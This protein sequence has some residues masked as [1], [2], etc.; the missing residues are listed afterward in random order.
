M[1]SEATTRGI[2]VRVRSRY[3]PDHSQPPERWLFVYTIEIANEG[4]DTVQLISRHWVITDAHGE[5]EEVRGPG[6]VGVQPVLPPG[7]SFEYTS[8]C[9][10]T[11][12]FG[13]MQG[14]YQM[15]TEEGETFEAEIATF[16]LSTPYAVN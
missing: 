3:S 8:F 2:R 10:L 1:S 12:P 4:E 15:L 6:V 16:R 14:T 13:S 5:V 7:E 11:T 9:P